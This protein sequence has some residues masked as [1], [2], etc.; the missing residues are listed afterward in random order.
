VVSVQDAASRIEALAQGAGGYVEKS[1]FLQ[2]RPGQQ[3][4]G[5]VVRVPRS[6]TG[7]IRDQIKKIAQRVESDKSEA[8]DVTRE[9]IDSE[10]RLRNMKVEEAQYLELMHRSSSTKDI[11]AITARI[12]AVRGRIEQL[13]GELRYLSHQVEMSSITITLSTEY[14][15]SDRREW[16]PLRSAQLAFRDMVE[17]LTGYADAMISFV[18]FIPVALLWI[19]TVTV[20]PILGW[21]VIRWTWKRLVQGRSEERPAS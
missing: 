19:M 18:L 4:A 21:K 15:S 14:I 6:R 2:A 1:E 20:L 9:F 17:G 5:I 12:S 8:R 11:I 3:S 16:H 7:T 10:A 13:T